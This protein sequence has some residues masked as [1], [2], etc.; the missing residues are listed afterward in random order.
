M[1]RST[2]YAPAL[3]TATACSRAVTGVGATEAEGSQA[4]MGNTAALVPKPMNAS[5]NT[6]RSSFSCPASFCGSRMP[7]RVKSAPVPYISENTSATK[8]MAAPLME[9]YR[10]LRPARME[11]ASCLW[12]TRGRVIRVRHS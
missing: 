2:A 12:V 1:V 6:P 4:Y 3:T 7:P 5:R 8:A 11:A 9:K 10:Y